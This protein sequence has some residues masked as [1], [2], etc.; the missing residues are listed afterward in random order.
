MQIFVGQ[1]FR[2]SLRSC[3][4]RVGGGNSQMDLSN[5][6]DA[7]EWFEVLQ[8]SKRT[9]TAMMTLAPGDD[10]GKKAE[11]HEKSDQ[12]L[13]M[14]SGKLSGTVGPETVNLKKGDVLLIR[15]GTPHR[16]RN[17]GRQRAVTFNVYS[18]PEYPPET[19]G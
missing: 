17:A 4:A 2:P 10:T 13:L 14:L 12:V 9:Q 6:R 11:A 19:K 18:P 1:R 5:T 8:T 3:R 15:A 16:F 7:T